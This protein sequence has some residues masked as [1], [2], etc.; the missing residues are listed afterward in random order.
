MRQTLLVYG[1]VRLK[2]P[3]QIQMGH[4]RAD[5]QTTSRLCEQREAVQIET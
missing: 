3:T 5:W 4:C 1:L 2:R